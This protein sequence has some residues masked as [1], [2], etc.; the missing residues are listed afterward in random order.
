MTVLIPDNVCISL[1]DM[2]LLVDTPLDFGREI[3]VAR[4]GRVD[5]VIKRIFINFG[6]YVI[7]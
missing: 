4:Q 2:P 3:G 5:L 6:H 1:T 7:Y